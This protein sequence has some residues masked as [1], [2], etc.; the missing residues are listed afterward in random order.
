MARS[1]ARC[2]DTVGGYRLLRK[3][4]SGS[5]ADV[6]LGHAASAAGISRTAAV[7]IYRPGV[8]PAS[9]DLEIDALSRASSPHVVELLD[10]ATDTNGL[11]CLILERLE[12]GGLAQLLADRDELE[13]G[14]FVTIIA[15]IAQ[16][17]AELHLAGV[18]HGNLG[19]TG[20]FFDGRG[21][22]V[23]AG[24]GSAMLL[25]RTVRPGGDPQA[26]IASIE[27][28][29][30]VATELRRLVALTTL[31]LARVRGREALSGSSAL[32]AWLEAASSQATGATLAAELS[33][34]VFDFAEAV[35]VDLGSTRPAEESWLVP[36]RVDLIGGRGGQS[37]AEA[38]Q[39]PSPGPKRSA[40][41]AHGPVPAAWVVALHLPEW[42]LSAAAEFTGS[43]A[44]SSLRHRLRA[45]LSP[46]RKPV[47]I[48]AGAVAVCLVL[49]VALIPPDQ[50]PPVQPAV[51]PAATEGAAETEQ[52]L[53]L[54]SI[55]GDDPVAAAE[56]LLQLRAQCF[57]DRSILCLDGVDQANSAAWDA[58]QYRIRK[59]QEGG[60]LLAAPELQQYA[61]SLLDRMG[62]SAII[63]LQPPTA[64][65]G[66]ETG[67]ASILVIR[68]EAGWRIRD[69]L[70]DP[71]AATGRAVAG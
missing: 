45:I 47:W 24:F 52:D 13:A 39:S 40:Q 63:A 15:P 50:E 48:A 36:G 42:L 29:N 64:L 6:F 69:I 11:P 37:T 23:I 9:I 43:S 1:Q 62:D 30:D 67:P 34:R 8:S 61:A 60:E 2:V 70:F 71:D 14:E 54:L 58:D 7:K 19:A 26:T 27:T 65:N 53:D 20:V 17:V 44:I 35:S 49:A 10:L 18:V 51:Q 25:D 33:R 41:S 3:L 59:I 55:T 16:A 66:S 68:T 4:D 31:V 22:P 32:V 5:R 57:R 12:P 56:Q 21:A 28:S 46:V 38:E